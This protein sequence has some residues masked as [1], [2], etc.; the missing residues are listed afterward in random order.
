MFM[1]FESLYAD[2]VFLNG[3]VYTMNERAL[4]A[5]A[6]CLRG[7]KIVFVGSNEGAKKKIG[8]NTE[9]IDLEGKM[10]MPGFVDA[11]SH[12]AYLTINVY[13]AD[14]KNCN[15]PEDCQRELKKILDKYPDREFIFGI[16]FDHSIFDE[17]G[18]QKEMLDEV[19]SE[20]PVIVYSADGHVLWLNSKALEYCGITEDTEEPYGGI[21]E[22]NDDGKLT[23][24]LNGFPAVTYVTTR[25]PDF[26]AEE[27][28]FGIKE[29]MDNAIKSGVTMCHDSCV[30]PDEF[31]EAYKV[32]D[33]NGLI[34]M[35]FR[36]A[37]AIYPALDIPI[38]AQ[39]ERVYRFH[40]DNYNDVV[41]SNTVK[42]LLDGIFST[43][44]AAVEK[45]YNDAPGER[46]EIQWPAD[47]LDYVCKEATKSGIQLE[48][49]CIGDR[50][51]RTAIEAVEKVCN[52]LGKGDYRS[53]LNHLQIIND[54]FPERMAD[55]GMIAVVNPQWVE[56]DGFYRKAINNLGIERASRMHPVK[57]FT[58]AGV[59][60]A[61]GSD[62]PVEHREKPAEVYYAP[63]IAIQ[64][65]ITRCA[66]DADFHDSRNQVN[67]NEAVSLEEMLKIYTI[68]GAYANYAE[69][70]TGSVE[71]GKYAD[72]I[73]LEKNLFEVDPR[74]IYKV[75]I[76][77]TLFE[78]SEVYVSEDMKR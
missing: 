19:E 23:G 9:I 48:F 65:G 63:L 17:K 27:Y 30:N 76:M 37:P 14:M 31:Y 51:G 70:I 52:K 77:M 53:L 35:R 41:Q 22:K 24:I 4:W 8:N 55:K 39:L 58:D 74:E 69:D 45:A 7:R 32:L 71:V 78:G 75:R 21:F 29:Y 57:S 25:I 11:H 62:V 60:V 43:R 3:K 56:H 26:S 66:I 2:K 38:D 49:H 5:E 40:N 73:V 16:N 34:N 64:Q 10:M 1:M 68:N 15:S 54:D 20:K 18:P 61:I 12:P 42:I 13:S 50:A 36:L 59:T 6:V 67:P 72:L 33:K 28:A 47:T 46:G 44:T